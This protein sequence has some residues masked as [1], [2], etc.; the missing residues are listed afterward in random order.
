[1][2]ILKTQKDEIQKVA[3]VY[4]EQAFLRL[5]QLETSDFIEIYEDA[6]TSIGVVF[7]FLCYFLYKPNKTDG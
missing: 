7:S 6:C 1:M 2:T 3:K 5:F 4:L